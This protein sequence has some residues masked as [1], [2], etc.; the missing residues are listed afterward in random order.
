MCA[1]KKNM[2]ES[3]KISIAVN[4]SKYTDTR[5]SFKNLM[6]SHSYLFVYLLAIL[7]L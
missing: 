6:E 3:L 1:G 5:F 4:N 7:G 2:D